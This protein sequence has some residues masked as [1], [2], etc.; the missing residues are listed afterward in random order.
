MDETK[1]LFNKIKRKDSGS[2][3]LLT[4]T[5]G[6]K[7]YSYIRR[8]VTDRETA[9]RIF[10]DTL[11]RFHASAQNYDC[12]DP[13]EAMLCLY[14]D[15]IAKTVSDTK[16]HS[17]EQPDQDLHSG[18][19]MPEK[20]PHGVAAP[21]FSD[22]SA[23]GED[24]V[25]SIADQPEA[26]WSI[27]SGEKFDFPD[28]KPRKRRNSSRE[29]KQSG[30]FVASFFYVLCIILLVIGI[31]AALWFL[32]GILA[33]MQILPDWDLGYSWFNDHIINWF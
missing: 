7:L 4:E 3:N 22:S 5:Y 9:D 19:E 12:E 30:S 28:D 20:V 31:V 32:I 33:D 1:A 8:N 6:W 29:K 18:V 10:N 2:F 15:E 24:A 26:P 11:A 16:P 21:V 17:Q 14:A 27:G 25:F 13:I 23:A